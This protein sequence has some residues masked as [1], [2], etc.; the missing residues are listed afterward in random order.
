M[1]IFAIAEVS[2]HEWQPETGMCKAY[3]RPFR[4]SAENLRATFRLI[5]KVE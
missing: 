2:K 1:C 4:P 5:R 3:Y